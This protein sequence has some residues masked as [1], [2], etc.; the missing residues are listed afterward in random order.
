MSPLGPL[1]LSAR[2]AAADSGTALAVVDGPVRWSWGELDRH[3][4]AVARRLIRAGVGPADRVAL[5]AAPSAA[6]IAA[7]HGIARVAAVAAPLG[8]GLTATE[9]AATVEVMNPRLAIC[10]PGHDA[11]AAALGRPLLTL[12]ELIASG[13]GPESELVDASTSDRAAPAVVVLTSGTT[14]HPKAAVLSTAALIASAEAWLAVLPAATGWLLT[15]GLGHV[16]GLGVVWRAALSSVPLVVLP[17]PDTTEILAALTGD[18]A[19]SHVSLVPTMLVRLLDS[20][21][22]GRPPATLRAILLG[23]G[24]IAPELVIR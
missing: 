6:A 11:A 7:L 4:D 24:P 3:A 17:R 18:P 13:P 16:G 5:L 19:P 20:V 1:A 10:G 12:E 23:G 9:L 15:L 21:A 14:G 8:L 2:R 22:D